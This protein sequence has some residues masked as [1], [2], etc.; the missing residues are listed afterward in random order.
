MREVQVLTVSKSLP[1]GLM[2][3]LLTRTESALH[4]HGASRVWIDATQPGM[5]VLAE[6]PEVPEILGGPDGA[7]PIAELAPRV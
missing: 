5:T 2:D 3:E 6:F 7:V 4:A 1:I